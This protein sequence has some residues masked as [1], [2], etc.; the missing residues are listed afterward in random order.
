MPCSDILSNTFSVLFKGLCLKAWNTVSKISWGFIY[1]FVEPKSIRRKCA[2]VSFSSSCWYYF[3]LFSTSLLPSETEALKTPANRALRPSQLASPPPNEMW[4]QLKHLPAEWLSF[5][6][7]MPIH[8]W[9]ACL[10]LST[11]IN[12]QTC[13]CYWWWK[14]WGET[15]IWANICQKKSIF[16]IVIFA[17]SGFLISAPCQTPPYSRKLWLGSN[18]NHD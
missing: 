1:L 6:R 12:S 4:L 13:S 14:G 16:P 17:W 11:A 2:E 5:W 18:Q 10:R 8:F 7:D 3:H 9:C 15:A